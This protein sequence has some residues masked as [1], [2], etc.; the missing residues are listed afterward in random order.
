MLLCLLPIVVLFLLPT[1]GR[2]QDVKEVVLG[3]KTTHVEIIPEK[4]ITCPLC[5]VVCHTGVFGS[6]AGTR[7][8]E[9]VNLDACEACG[10]CIENCPTAAIVNNFREG[11]CSC[12]TCYV[13]ESVGALAGR[14]K[15]RERK[16]PGDGAAKPAIGCTTLGSGCTEKCQ[17]DSQP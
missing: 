15:H 13:I 14:E 5:A 4:C 12:P 17:G 8:Y 11:V 3:V 1:G 10:A 2:R 9:V 7:R 6:N 16:T